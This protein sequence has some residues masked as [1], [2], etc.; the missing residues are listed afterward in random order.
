VQNWD[1]FWIAPKFEQQTLHVSGVDGP[2]DALSRSSSF[3]RMSE[4]LRW[5]QFLVL[6]MVR[7]LYH[8]WSNSQL[9]VNS[10]ETF[11]MNIVVGL[12]GG[13]TGFCVADGP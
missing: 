7:A 1:R 13:P 9:T 4:L 3:Y 10:N 8:E 11:K 12:N 5:Q 6:R 2:R